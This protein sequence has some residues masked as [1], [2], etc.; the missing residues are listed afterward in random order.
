MAVVEMENVTFAFPRE[1]LET[2][3]VNLISSGAFEPIS[4]REIINPDLLDALSTEESNP[5]QELYKEMMDFLRMTGYEPPFDERYVDLNEPFN[6]DNTIRKFQLM[7]EGIRDFF[8]RKN[9]L[10]KNL[11][12]YNNVLFHVNLLAGLDVE[13]NDFAELTRINLLFGR[14]PIRNYE[15]LVE[16]SLK[17]PILILELSRDKNNSRIFVFTT[18]DFLDDAYKILKS[19]Y[20]EE[21]SLPVDQRG[22]P[23]EIRER[24]ESL[25]EITKLSIRE[26]DFA[27]KKVLY[28][29]KE[30]ID[31]VYPIVLI[32]KRTYDLASF[33][34]FTPDKNLCF[35]SG[36]MPGEDAEVLEKKMDKDVLVI[37]KPA[38]EVKKEKA[39]DIPVKLKNHGVIFKGFEFITDMFGTP[40]YNEIDPT[41]FITVFF[42]LMYGFMLG[43]VGHGS[44]LLL[45]GYLMYRRRFQK[46]G[47]V[48]MSAA[49]SSI[50]FGFMYGSIFGF[51]W[52]PTLW[53]K[54]ILKI[55]QLLVI[56][57]YFGIG[58]IN[59]GM[60]LNVINGFRQR[61]WEKA[62]FSAEGIAG[63]IF[64][65]TAILTGSFYLVKGKIPF[66]KALLG[67]ILLVSLISMFLKK[68]F[69]QIISHEKKISLPN[70]FL[71]E[72][73]FG[74]FDALIR[75]LSNT[76]SYV[77][78]A[79]F[80]L[81]HEILFL[82]FW[83][84]TLM[85]LPA[86]GGGIWATFIFLIGQI[87]L[88]GLEGL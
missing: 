83:T 33:N 10:N 45:F 1:K 60:V 19:A 9:E 78:L 46:M 55:N 13:L 85:V 68:P 28:S 76:L 57:I 15:T 82:A 25:I 70:G 64:Y 4:F 87:I 77:R 51:D 23:Y 26:N 16:S 14:V 56:S 2:V 8:N 11:Q 52:I 69:G 17:V 61:N 80:A 53:I 58:M 79:A 73:G 42:I 7:N 32:R 18:P 30:F 41:P 37:N 86:P 59:F 38:E 48:I 22:T 24:M 88:V 49:L 50:F 67:G 6:I 21:D 36:W 81:T 27:I 66:N 74:L 84:M 20:F 72:S 75:F 43:D 5:Y 12:T 3:H 29:N 71:V 47:V 44:T 65:S 35:L 40:N 39:I 63:L 54:P 62:I 31:K 34:S